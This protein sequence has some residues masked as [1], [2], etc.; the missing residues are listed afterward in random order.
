MFCA[1]LLVQIFRRD[2]RQSVF[3][4]FFRRVIER[5]VLVHIILQQDWH[6]ALGFHVS[7]LGIEHLGKV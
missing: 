4:Q 5:G 7:D 2:E 3:G 6:Q 1:V